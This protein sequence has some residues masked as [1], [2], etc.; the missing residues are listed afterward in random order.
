MAFT[1][2]T[3]TELVDRIQQDFVSRLS[4]V[5]AVLRRSVV[6]V[7][8]RVLAGAAH[9]LH[10]HLD[11]LSRQLF[12]DTQQSA[13]LIRFG[14]LFGLTPTAAAFATGNVSVTGTNGSVIRVGTLLQRADGTEYSVT[15]EQT[16]SGGIATAPVIAVT[17]DEDSDCD[18]GVVLNFESPI[19][20]VDAAS[21]VATDGLSGGSDGETE[22]EFRTRIL[23]RMRNPPQGG[24]AADYTAWAKGVSGVTR[25]WPVPLGLGAGT[26]VVRFVR[27]D[28]LSL[29]PDAG[30][31]TAVQTYIDALKPAHATVTVVA[32][33]ASPLALT[34]HISP[35]TSDIRAA[36][37]AQLTDLLYR[38]AEPGGT[39]QL[40]DIR[41]AIGNAAGLDDYTLSSP[42]ADV[43]H[44]TG[45]LATL[46]VI[47]YV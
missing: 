7:L 32:P 2:P 24:S 9:M 47:T 27:D 13:Y 34:L 3:L 20:G 22:E 31:V 17:A 45:Q 23:E 46:G 18:E 29:I 14:A 33:V 39:I 10:G 36:V 35:D 28:D 1:R 37:S 5:G 41:T 42:V 11:Y 6:Y 40:S 30:E 19:A 12:P 43:T 25:V 44:T 16:I 4:L 38:D 21:T 15:V 8:S 26:V